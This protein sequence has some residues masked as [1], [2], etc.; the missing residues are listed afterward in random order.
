MNN[1]QINNKKINYLCIFKLVNTRHV[2]AYYAYEKLMLEIVRSIPCF[3][4]KVEEHMANLNCHQSWMILTSGFRFVIENR[5]HF[6][7]KSLNYLIIHL[8]CC[9]LCDQDYT[10]YASDDQM[11]SFKLIWRHARAIF[12]F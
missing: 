5:F 1:I 4:K 2:Y 3:N 12:C 10:H 9:P 8:T 11:S 7:V 6:D